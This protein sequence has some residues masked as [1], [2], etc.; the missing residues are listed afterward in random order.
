MSETFAVIAGGGTAGHVNP[1][2]ALAGELV[3]RGHPVSSITWVGSARGLEA[4]TVPHHG[5]PLHLLPGRGVQRRLTLDN[6]G[7]LW[8]LLVAV[9]RAMQ[10]VRRLRPQVIVSLGGYASVACSLAG[11][12]Q[13]I[14]IVVMEQNKR[15]GLANRLSARVAKATAVSF[16]GTPLPRAV[17]TGNPLR[18]E[19]MAAHRDRVPVHDGVAILVTGGSLGA[20]RINDATLDLVA[21]W[22]DRSDVA[23]HHVVGPRNY[24]AVRA[25]VPAIP[26]DG[27]RYEVVAYEDDMPAAMAA[28]DVVVCRA[29]SGLVSEIAVIGVPSVLVPWSG[30]A[31]DH[32]TANASVLVDVGAAELISDADLSGARLGSTLDALLAA[33]ERLETMARACKQVARPDAAQRV[34]DLVEEHSRG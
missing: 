6:V 28:A 29:S 25:R 32:Q 20:M 3:A 31:E 22:A 16:E 4:T 1:G 30:A 2:L 19:V 7:A 11:W 26:P 8:G 14:P 5:Y 15:P 12:A 23:L 18:A 13:R 27:L 24:D 21:M 34:A 10:I 33:P 17:V 9:V